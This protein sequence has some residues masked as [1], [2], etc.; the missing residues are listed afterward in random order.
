MSLMID[1]IRKGA[2]PHVYLREWRKYKDVKAPA[3]ADRLGIERESYY[4]LE[5]QPFTLSVAELLVLADALGIEHYQLWRLPPEPG[6]RPRPSLD[7]IV[8]SEPDA[9]VEGLADML[10]RAVGKAS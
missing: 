9:Q 1:R 2:K 10:R 4:R 7:A 8:A 6:L 3:M 5:R